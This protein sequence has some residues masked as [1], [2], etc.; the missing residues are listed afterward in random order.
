MF[1]FQLST[2]YAFEVGNSVGEITYH[3]NNHYYVGIAHDY[4]Y[5]YSLY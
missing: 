3:A 2:N 4:N 5:T 1:D